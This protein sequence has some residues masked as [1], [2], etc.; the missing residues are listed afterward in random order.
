MEYLAYTFKTKTDNGRLSKTTVFMPEKNIV[1]I[2]RRILAKE[3]DI[4]N[5]WFTG[6]FPI[7]VYKD[8]VLME[9]EMVFWVDSFNTIQE[10]FKKLNEQ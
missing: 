5:G 10:V 7:Y 6:A 9:S 3:Y 1:V 8:Y 2:N 4:K